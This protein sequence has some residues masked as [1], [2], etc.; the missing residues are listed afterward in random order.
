M[1]EMNQTG[2][3]WDIEENRPANPNG[4]YD[5]VNTIDT[6]HE[7]EVHMIEQFY[8]RQPAQI[9]CW[10]G[11][12]NV[13]RLTDYRNRVLKLKKLLEML[14]QFDTANDNISNY[15]QIC[16]YE[17]LLDTLDERIKNGRAEQ[18]QLFYCVKKKYFMEMKEKRGSTVGTELA[19]AA[20]TDVTVP[21]DPDSDAVLSRI[22]RSGG[23]KVMLDVRKHI[24]S[25]RLPPGKETEVQRIVNDLPATLEEFVISEFI[26]LTTK[27]SEEE[28]KVEILESFFRV[29]A[30]AFSTVLTGLVSLISYRLKR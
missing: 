29:L 12:P 27:L 30:I 1:I 8:A 4:K 5:E 20:G 13:F 7:R 26:D 16:K 9:A 6:V 23:V 22:A 11:I 19:P 2:P 18:L 14:N 17:I 24:N 21:T 28:L 25:V 10:T 3:L 15:L